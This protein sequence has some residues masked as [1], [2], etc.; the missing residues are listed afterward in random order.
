MKI[1]SSFSKIKENLYIFTFANVF[2]YTVGSLVNLPPERKVSGHSH[3]SSH[4]MGHKWLY[5]TGRRDRCHALEG[6]INYQRCPK[7][8]QNLFWRPS[9]NT[10]HSVSTDS[11]KLASRGRAWVFP[12]ESKHISTHWTFCSPGFPDHQLVKTVTIILTNG[13]INC[14]N[15]VSS[16]CSAVFLVFFILPLSFPYTFS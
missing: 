15:Q 12:C 14:N 16:V 7:S 5:Y 9:T 10:V 1:I 8:P 2:P 6:V 4:L 3:C 11:V 13:H